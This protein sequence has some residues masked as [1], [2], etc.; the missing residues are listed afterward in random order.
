MKV[1][2]MIAEL[3]KLPEDLDLYMASDAEG[4]GYEGVWGVS[5]SGE[6]I[7]IHPDDCRTDFIYDYCV[8]CNIDTMGWENYICAVCGKNREEEDEH[9]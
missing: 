9:N 2:E 8:H 1:K 5:V 4:N 7:I 3:E 6:I